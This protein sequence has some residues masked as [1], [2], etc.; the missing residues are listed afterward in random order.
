MSLLRT[1][2]C[3]AVSFARAA[4]G[5]AFS[6][7]LLAGGCAATSGQYGVHDGVASYGYGPSVAGYTQSSEGEIED[8]G[9]PVQ[10][11]PPLRIHQ[12]PDDPSQPWSPNY[13]GGPA[14]PSLAIAPSGGTDVAAAD[15]GDA[16]APAP[17]AGYA[18]MSAEDTLP[19]QPLPDDLPP[20]FRRRLLSTE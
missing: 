8:D 17:D 3:P 5:L 12:A 6:A 7:A 19:W 10:A 4:L 20:A 9:L 13:G 18:G 16:Y 15:T 14:R 1:G 2:A 11:A